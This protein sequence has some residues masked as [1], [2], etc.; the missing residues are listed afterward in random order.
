MR[1]TLRIFPVCSQD[2]DQLIHI[3]P[4]KAGNHAIIPFVIRTYFDIVLMPMHSKGY[5]GL[6]LE[7][8]MKKLDLSLYLIFFPENQPH[9]RSQHD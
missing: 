7:K 3:L 9:A 1:E 4:F 6:S 8:H 2:S 5:P